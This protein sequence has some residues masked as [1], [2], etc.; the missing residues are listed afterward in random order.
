[1][2]IQSVRVATAICD[3]TKYHGHLALLITVRGTIHLSQ[4]DFCILYPHLATMLLKQTID[5][6]RAI[7]LNIAAS[8]EFLAKVM[9]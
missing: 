2:L 7:D 4:S 3:E 1:M 6:R 5:R 8:L 9:P